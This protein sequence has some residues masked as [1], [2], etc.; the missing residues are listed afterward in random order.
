MRKLFLAGTLPLVGP[1]PASG[2][3]E[4]NVHDPESRF[5]RCV[6]AHKAFDESTKYLRFQ[7][8]QA[9]TA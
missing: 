1:P 8:P 7:V 9:Q 3:T 5:P 4:E 6:F 2:H